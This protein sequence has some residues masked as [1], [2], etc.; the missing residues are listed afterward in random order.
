MRESQLDPATPQASVLRLG[1][2]AAVAAAST[3][4]CGFVAW[5]DPTTPGGAIPVCPT[6]ALLGIT[7]PGCGS[8]RMLYALLHIDFSR[9]LRYNAVGVAALALLVEAYLR[10]TWGRLHGRRIRGWQHL[11]WAPTAV[12]TVALIWLGVRNIPFKPFTALHV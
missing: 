1:A 6:K 5:T 9:A 4:V 7:C 8:A 12:L 3:A 11:S 2:P 10:W